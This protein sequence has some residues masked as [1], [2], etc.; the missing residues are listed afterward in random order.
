MTYLGDPSVPSAGDGPLWLYADDAE[1]CR[2][3][4]FGEES[5]ICIVILILYYC[6]ILLM[7]FIIHQQGADPSTRPPSG[8]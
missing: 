8:H 1:L 6:T 4:L 2:K 7:L 3:F 5:H